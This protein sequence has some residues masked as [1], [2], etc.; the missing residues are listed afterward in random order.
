[1]KNI[2]YISI[3]FCIKFISINGCK[4][5]SGSQ[6]S[7]SSPAFTY[8][9]P[10]VGHA[11]IVK[12][13]TYAFKND[14]F[15]FF[16]L[17]LTHQNATFSLIIDF[18]DQNNLIFNTTQKQIPINKTYHDT[19]LYLINVSVIDPFLIYESKTIFVI[20]SNFTS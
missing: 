20:K 4:T 17:I 9:F 6:T 5:N 18:G 11:L 10:S 1:M 7:T 13:P 16:V 2:L 8:T 19:G 3:Y 12:N 14:Q 15:T